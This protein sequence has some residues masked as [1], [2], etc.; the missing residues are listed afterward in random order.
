MISSLLR[1]VSIGGC[2]VVLLVLL[3]SAARADDELHASAGQL[4]PRP[5]A[6]V[7]ATEQLTAFAELVGEPSAAV[8]QRL[9]IDPSLVPSAVAA[10]D[11]RVNRK[12][13]GKIRT[14]VG[15]SILGVG[16]IASYVLWTTAFSRDGDG[17]SVA[18]DRALLSYVMAASAA[19]GLGIGISGIVSMLRQSEAETAAVD[20]YQSPHMPLPPPV[21]RP[22]YSATP[23]RYAVN[24][25]L[26]SLSF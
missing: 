10:A 7:I 21:S 19:I 14:A 23:A 18:V 1:F 6:P 17:Y 11:A 9:Q 15:F 4:G 3:S 13:S 26:L 2:F 20:R 24:L 16:G 12:T 8:R 22:A 25:P 5:A